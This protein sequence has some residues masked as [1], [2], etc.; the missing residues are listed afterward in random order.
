MMP[1]KQGSTLHKRNSTFIAAKPKS[2]LAFSAMTGESLKDE[3][4]SPKTE[5]SR[6]SITCADDIVLEK[7][8]VPEKDLP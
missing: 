5:S 3:I 7:D 6:S 4:E 2:S 8:K 1:S